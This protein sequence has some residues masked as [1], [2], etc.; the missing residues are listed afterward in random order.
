MKLSRDS[1]ADKKESLFST[2][3]VIDDFK[4]TERTERSPSIVSLRRSSATI[5]SE[6]KVLQRSASKVRERTIIDV[7]SKPT[8]TMKAVTVTGSQGRKDFES[9]FLGG[10]G[11]IS[12]LDMGKLN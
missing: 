4:F 12:V 7:R 6:P 11:R 2:D 5:Q 8:I 10:S 9:L 3:E 1:S